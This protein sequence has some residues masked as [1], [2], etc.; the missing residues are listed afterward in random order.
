MKLTKK[1]GKLK[2][3]MVAVQVTIKPTVY[4]E[5]LA[6]NAEDAVTAVNE[7]ALQIVADNLE[8][9]QNEAMDEFSEATEKTVKV[10]SC[11]RANQ[12]HSDSEC[13]LCRASE[14]DGSES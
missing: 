11:G 1:Q 4:I 2:S 9:F 5:V 3:Y 7:D 12:Y 13:E 8:A 14:D 10:I 6:K